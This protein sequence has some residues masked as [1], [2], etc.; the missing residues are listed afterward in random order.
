MARKTATPKVTFL[1]PGTAGLAINL[2]TIR[3]VDYAVRGARYG[4]SYVVTAPVP[5][6]E[7]IRDAVAEK[8]KGGV[9]SWAHGCRKALPRITKALGE[10]GK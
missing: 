1:L 4:M 6:A 7:K 3:G 5:V 10:V 9:T 8:S 2:D